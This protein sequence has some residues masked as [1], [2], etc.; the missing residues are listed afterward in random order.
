MARP[1]EEYFEGGDLIT[2]LLYELTEAGYCLLCFVFRLH[3][4]PGS[5]YFVLAHLVYRL[6]IALLGLHENIAQVGI[7]KG[8]YRLP[9]EPP[10][11]CLNSRIVEVGILQSCRFL[12]CL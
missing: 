7:V 4:P 12:R 1:A 8:R 2:M 3:I 6:L 9:H 10:G 5:E 11:D